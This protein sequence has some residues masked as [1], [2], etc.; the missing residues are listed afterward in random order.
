[1]ANAL[2]LPPQTPTR[3]LSLWFSEPDASIMQ[4]K[5]PKNPQFPLSFVSLVLPILWPSFFIY[6]LRR[7]SVVFFFRLFLF[8]LKA[9]KTISFFIFLN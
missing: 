9:G 4:G 5:E 8:L 1:L 2:P 3:L 7:S 6:L